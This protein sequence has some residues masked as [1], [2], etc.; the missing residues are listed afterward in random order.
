MGA[1][2]AIART[3]CALL[4][5]GRGGADGARVIL[6]AVGEG[7]EPRDRRVDKMRVVPHIP[8][9]QYWKVG[10]DNY[11][12]WAIHDSGSSYILVSTGLY[13]ELGLAIDKTWS[14]GNYRVAGV[15]DGTTR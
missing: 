3:V 8:G 7:V 10:I 13:K 12:V 6:L 9:A 14:P 5:T 15:A 1:V 2:S 4:Q 11:L